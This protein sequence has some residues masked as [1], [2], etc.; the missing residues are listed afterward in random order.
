MSIEGTSGND[1][2]LAGT[3]GNDMI[4][5][6]G[7]DDVVDAGD[8]NDVIYAGDGN[9]TVYGGAGNDQLDGGA[10]ADLLVG[11]DGNDNYVVDDVEDVVVELTNGGIDTVKSWISYTLRPNV[12]ILTLLGTDDLSGAG[13]ELNNAIRG[14]DGNNSLSGGGGNDSIDGGAGDD[15]IRGGD[16]NDVLIGGS[17]T[18]TVS[19]QDASSGVHV[20]LAISANQNTGGSG[21]DKLSLFE[22]LVGSNFDDELFGDNKSNVINAIAGNDRLEGRGG[23]DILVGGIGNDTFVFSDVSTNGFDQIRGFVAGSDKLEF[24]TSDGYT[25]ASLFH[26][27]SA[28]HVLSYDGHDLAKFDLIH[29][30][31]QDP[32]MSDILLDGVAIA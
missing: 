23:N 16:G 14:N 13:N 18:D 4:Y 2:N 22:N 1:T 32:F 24:H 6:R 10:G 15:I 20:D 7:G 31:S 17:G 28:T 5:A 27:E 30:V 3:S 19:Y 29:G 21:I 11:G 26:Y 25:D 8:G 12:E 9:D